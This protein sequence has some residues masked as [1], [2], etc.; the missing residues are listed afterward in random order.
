MSSDEYY[1]S[2]SDT[3]PEDEDA[4]YNEL[5]ALVLELH[6]LTEKNKILEVWKLSPP[7]I[8]ESSSLFYSYCRIVFSF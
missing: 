2:T 7:T 5:D 8:V 4:A 1:T 3:D 6:D